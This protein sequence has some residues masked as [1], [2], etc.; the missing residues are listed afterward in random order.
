MREIDE[1]PFTEKSVAA[2]AGI[3]EAEAKAMRSRISSDLYK[4]IG[5]QVR[6]SKA[7]VDALLN[8]AGLD[9]L[10]HPTPGQENPTSPPDG[11]VALATMRIERLCPNPIWVK[12]RDPKTRDLVNVRVRN[13]RVMRLGQPINVVEVDGRLHMAIPRAS[14]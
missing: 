4:K 1:F 14:A 12:C 10:P 9:S 2:A 3:T 11:D 6:Y 7:G 13:N 5:G 8:A